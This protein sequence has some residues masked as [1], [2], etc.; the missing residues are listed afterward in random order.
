MAAVVGQ[1]PTDLLTAKHRVCALVGAAVAVLLVAQPM[2][3]PAHAHHI[4]A[5]SGAGVAIP[6]ITHNQM[7]VYQQYFDAIVR[8]AD[9]LPAPEPGFR[10]VLN[11]AKLQ[12]TYCL[13][14]LMPGAVSDEDSPF[15]ECA[16][17]Y[18]A[19]AKALTEDLREASPPPGEFGRLGAAIDRDLLLAG[20]GPVCGYSG[21][22]FNTADL[23]SPQWGRV[24][25]HPPS[26]A[27]LGGGVLVLALPL[28]WLWRG[29]GRVV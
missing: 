27:A 12:K 24:I 25:G 14:G 10:R 18:L 2:V 19:A 13:W 21:E 22:D 28:A 9:R 4:S 23:V 6:S 7:L 17:A 20:A 26:V 3:G 5:G 16:H 15:N 1:A 29:R 11:Y 8:A